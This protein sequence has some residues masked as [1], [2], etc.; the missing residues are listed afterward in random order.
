MSGKEKSMNRRTEMELFLIFVICLMVLCC[1]LAITSQ[2]VAQVPSEEESLVRSKIEEAITEAKKT[3]RTTINIYLDEDPGIVQTGD[4]VHADAT[5]KLLDGS[6]VYTTIERVSR[7]QKH[8]MA[9]GY[10]EPDRFIPLEFLAG[11]ETDIP[12]VGD[13]ALGMKKGESKTIRLLSD[14]LPEAGGGKELR[15][16]S[17]TREMGLVLKK[18]KKEFVREFKQAP[19]V[20]QE[21]FLSP[22]FMSSVI[23]L[24]EYD[25]FIENHAEDGKTT[26]EPFGSVTVHVEGD[27]VRTV[28]SPKTGEEFVI[29]AKTG[30]IT[31]TNGST[32]TVDLSERTEQ[33][34]M[35]L[36]IEVVSILKASAIRDRSIQW[37]EDHDEG[38]T[39][40]GRDHKPS[41][42][43]LFSKNCSWCE[44][45]FSETMDDPRIKALDDRFVWIRVDS[46]EHDEFKALYEQDG[47]PM[48]VVLS[49]GGDVLRKMSGYQD[50]TTLRT[51]LKACLKRVL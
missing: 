14:D 51:E 19:V 11:E 15:E 26:D 29:G 21:L 41:V 36:E 23:D 47:Y 25:V 50:A 31:S 20:G 12:G 13:A 43:V 5:L 34:G 35:T 33:E 9:K 45:L 37:I 2:A 6:L 18:S 17:C 10:H 16:L 24:N 46:S 38:M 22:Y 7:D 4:L 42:L 49:S 8:K 30:K 27:T 39:A 44:K 40:A 3:G 28:L 32:F 48:I 1:I